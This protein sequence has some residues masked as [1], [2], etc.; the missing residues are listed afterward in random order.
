MNRKFFGVL[1][2]I[3]IISSVFFCSCTVTHS[4][5]VLYKKYLNGN[6][7]KGY[8]SIEAETV[9]DAKQVVKEITWLNC[10]SVVIITVRQIR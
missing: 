2:L 3:V 8:A 6:Y 9:N 1:V 7:L 4:Y 10:D 5:T